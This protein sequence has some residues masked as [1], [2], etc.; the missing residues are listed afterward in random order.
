VADDVAAG[1]MGR[2][3]L[4]VMIIFWLGR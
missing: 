3:A 2:M 1:V 4:E